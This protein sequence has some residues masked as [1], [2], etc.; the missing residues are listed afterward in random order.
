MG[1][2]KKMTISNSPNPSIYADTSPLG[3]DRI[4]IGVALGSLF[5]LFAIIP[6]IIVAQMGWFVSFL[7]YLIAIAIL[8][9]FEIGAGRS[10]KIAQILVFVLVL[11]YIPLAQLIGE[12]IYGV[13]YGFYNT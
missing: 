12:V 2:T 4:I 1:N 10:S 3:T 6:W 8:K 9:G 11:L 13:Q 5:G 7:G